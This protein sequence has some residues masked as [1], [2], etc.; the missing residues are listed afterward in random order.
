MPTRKPGRQAH[1]R[2]QIFVWGPGVHHVMVTARLMSLRSHYL[3][4][5]DPGA[6]KKAEESIKAELAALEAHPD[7]REAEPYGV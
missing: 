5:R 1:T 4:E 3:Y 2:P 7:Y 6:F